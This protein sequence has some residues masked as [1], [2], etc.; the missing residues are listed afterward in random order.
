M[1]N[2]AA[3]A[4]FHVRM[5]QLGNRECSLQID[6]HYTVPSLTG[7]LNDGSEV[8]GG[9]RAVNQDVDSAECGYGLIDGV[10]PIL[11]VC[12]VGTKRQASAPG[13]LY[14]AAGGIE[15]VAAPRDYG[16]VGAVFGKRECDGATDA[17]RAA[18]YECSPA[19]E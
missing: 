11:L 3:A 14:I 6:V 15:R 10:L 5:E 1:D 18:G 19:V 9:S 16:D 12:H 17:F 8:F 13:C 2:R 4:V 7:G